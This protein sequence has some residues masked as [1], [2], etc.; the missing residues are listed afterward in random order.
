MHGGGG[1]GGG[2]WRI[3]P[4]KMLEFGTSKMCFPCILGQTEIIL[5]IVYT[6]AVSNRHGFMSSKPH[7]GFTILAFKLELID[8]FV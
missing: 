1:G 5:G 4:C 2:F 3:H 7:Q 6:D 8:E